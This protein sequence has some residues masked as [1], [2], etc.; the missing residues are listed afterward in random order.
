MAVSQRAEGL[1]KMDTMIEQGEKQYP[2]HLNENQ[3]NQNL[4]LSVQIT[5]KPPDDPDNLKD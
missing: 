5:E 1:N 4:I 3:S 2:E